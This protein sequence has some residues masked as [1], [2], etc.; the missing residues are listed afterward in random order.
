MDLA[1][2]DVSLL[3]QTQVKM[4]LCGSYFCLF[5]ATPEEFRRW[6]W[7]AGDR[8]LDGQLL[9]VLNGP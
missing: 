3:T 5:S 4:S 8:P 9:G 7:I 6:W 2:N 1:E